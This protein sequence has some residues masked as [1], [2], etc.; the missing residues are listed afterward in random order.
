M[1]QFVLY[2][3]KMIHEFGYSMVVGD[4]VAA[5]PILPLAWWIWP[6]FLHVWFDVFGRS[7][8]P[9]LFLYLHICGDFGTSGLPGS[10]KIFFTDVVVNMARSESI[11]TLPMP[12]YVD[13]LSLI[14]KVVSVLVNEW[15]SF[16]AFLLSLGIFMKDL[17]EKDCRY[18]SAC[19][20][21]LVGFDASDT[22]T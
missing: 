21:L 10:F 17:K 11:L 13:D 12:V 1:V 19:F 2:D 4:V 5:Y 9:S 20:R 8:T 14:G 6:F 18:G 16:K 15:Q 3:V 22:H 7:P